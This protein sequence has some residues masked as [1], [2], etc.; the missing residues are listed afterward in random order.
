MSLFFVIPIFQCDTLKNYWF[1]INLG[2]L[3]NSGLLNSFLQCINYLLMSGLLGFVF[4]TF[5]FLIFMYNIFAGELISFFNGLHMDYRF[6]IIN[7]LHY[8]DGLLWWVTYR[9]VSYL[10]VLCIL[11]LFLWYISMG[12]SDRILIYENTFFWVTW[13]A[14]SMGYFI[15][16]K[17]TTWIRLLLCDIFFWVTSMVY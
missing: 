9:L 1:V 4:D 7:L 8:F 2:N 11:C 3:I 14:F 5:L 15:T 17:N 10:H 6:V 13:W 16:N 12:D